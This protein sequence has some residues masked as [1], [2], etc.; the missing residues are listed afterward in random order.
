MPVKANGPAGFPGPLVSTRTDQV[1]CVWTG[2]V[3]LFQVSIEVIATRIEADQSHIERKESI[4]QVAWMR[5]IFRPQ[6][7]PTLPPAV[8]QGHPQYNDAH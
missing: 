7:V 2:I 4:L 3:Q 5:G 8:N 1:S 6:T